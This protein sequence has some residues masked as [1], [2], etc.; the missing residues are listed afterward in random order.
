[1]PLI[2]LYVGYLLRGEPL[3]S[4]VMPLIFLY[5]GYLLRGELCEVAGDGVDLCGFV[6]R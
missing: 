6:G 1:M 5:V 4:I 2:F 3:W